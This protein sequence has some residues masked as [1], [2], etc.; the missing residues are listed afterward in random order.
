LITSTHA[1]DEARIVLGISRPGPIPLGE[2][3][4]AAISNLGFDRGSF[5]IGV[6]RVYRNFLSESV[7]SELRDEEAGLASTREIALLLD[8]DCSNEANFPVDILVDIQAP[9][10]KPLHE[11]GERCT[12]HG[13]DPEQEGQRSHAKTLA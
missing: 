9:I 2:Q 4:E 7:T 1:L 8:G 12:R 5:A 11:P 10:A 6:A 3:F 13:R